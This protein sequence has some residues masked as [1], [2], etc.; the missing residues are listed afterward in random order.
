MTTTLITIAPS[1]YCEKAR[2]ALSLAGID[3]IEEPHTPFFHTS[4]VKQAGAGRTTPVLKSVS[5]TLPSSD[6]ITEWITHQPNIKWHPYGT[7]EFQEQI[8]EMEIELG[9]KLGILTR[10]LAYHELLPHKRHVQICMSTAPKSEQRYF[11]LGFPVFRWLMRKGLNITES[12]SK[13]ARRAVH[14]ILETT[15]QYAEGDFLIGNTLSIADVAFASLVAP[16]VLPEEYGSPLPAFDLLPP[17]AKE[18]TNEFR[19]TSAGQRVLKLYSE[20]RS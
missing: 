15:E 10:L 12:S 4:A 8:R 7:G 14:E 9:R 6:A 16:I 5:E 3:Y 18:M 13:K 1:H 19:A 20:F 2:W 11:S 17:S